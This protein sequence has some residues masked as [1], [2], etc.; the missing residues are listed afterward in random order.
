[1]ASATTSRC[2]EIS[3]FVK[4]E[5]N[6]KIAEKE[7]LHDKDAGL[8]KITFERDPNGSAA[9]ASL[10]EMAQMIKVNYKGVKVRVDA[11]GIVVTMP[12]P[13]STTFALTYITAVMSLCYTALA[14]IRAAG[15][16]SP[17]TYA[18]TL[19]VGFLST[20]LSLIFVLTCTTPNPM[21]TT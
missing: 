10:A 16:L 4:R 18:F 1:M 13:M 7:R 20:I 17:S 5:S 19:E 21:A 15:M 8:I 3:A 2:D 14:V 9:E 11:R 12:M 6:N